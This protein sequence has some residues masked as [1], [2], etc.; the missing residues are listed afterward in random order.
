MTGFEVP[1]PFD[2]LIRRLKD[3]EMGDDI[4]CIMHIDYGC[5]YDT[6]CDLVFEKRF[7]EAIALLL[8]T[9]PTNKA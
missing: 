8:A 3:G 9:V 1:Y 2:E 6:S 4:P 5:D 7:D